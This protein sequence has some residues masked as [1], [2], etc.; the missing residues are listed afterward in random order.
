VSVRWATPAAVLAVEYLVLSVLVDLPTSGPATSFVAAIRVAL[1][2]VIG[3]VVAGALI[4]G[5][6][7]MPRI[8]VEL[9]PWRPWPALAA[10]VAAWSLTAVIAHE[11]LRPGAPPAGAAPLAALVASAALTLMLA[12]FIAAPPL[13]AVRLVVSTWRLPILATALGLLTWRAAHLG[14]RLW[15]GLT[16]ITLRSVAWTLSLVS[17]GVTVDVE[18]GLVGVGE[19]MVE[20]APVCSGV[21]GVG[22]VLVFQAIWM[23]LARARLRTSRAL[24]L[25]PLGALAA[26]AANIARITALVLVGA[27]GR[28]ALAIGG[29]HSKVGWVLFIGIALGSIALAERVTW[30]AR[31]APRDDAAT[32]PALPDS[33]TAWVG[34]FLAVLAAALLTSVWTTGPLDR[35][36][37]VRVAAGAAALVAA[38]RILPRPSVRFGWMPV[39][40]AAIAGAVWLLRPAGDGEPLAAAVAALGTTERLV[41]IAA[42]VA[43]ACVIVP[44]VEELAFRGFLLPWLVAPDFERVPPRAWT[45]PAVLG[46]SLAFG[47]MHSDWALA[48]LTGVAF[49]AARLWR[50]RLSDAVL[51]HALVNAGIAAAVLLGGRWDLWM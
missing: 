10:Q 33:V 16:A 41:W 22:L 39:A 12:V 23:S 11:L 2:V 45:W 9:P 48:S 1:P 3:A 17:D 21:D 7:A 4:A 38:R 8:S 28:E 26:V 49:A 24:L 20:I 19:F 47:A 40:V 43:G 42:R 50:G 29:F 32:Q 13:W 34:P 27:S 5:T 46:S 15:G 14:E 37:V 25:L 6:A 36:Y 44:V 18:R 30:I 35:A 31:D 51:A